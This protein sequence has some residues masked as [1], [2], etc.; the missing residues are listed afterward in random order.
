MCVCLTSAE[1]LSIHYPI[2]KPIRYAFR[3][4]IF[5]FPRTKVFA[6]TASESAASETA[7]HSASI[8]KRLRF[9]NDPLFSQFH[10]AYHTAME[11]AGCSETFRSQLEMPTIGT[12]M[13]VFLQEMCIYV[14]FCGFVIYMFVCLYVFVCVYLSVF[15]CVCE[16][17]I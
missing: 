8:R 16:C 5:A 11:E 12:P 3:L 1:A 17:I 4:I 7:R 2:V 6:K 15:V 9:G 14:W 10:L 13:S